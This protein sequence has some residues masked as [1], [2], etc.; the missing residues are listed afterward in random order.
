MPNC[1][2][3]E[4]SSQNQ[5]YFAKQTGSLS[6]EKVNALLITSQTMMYV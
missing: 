4:S 6:G 3:K 2:V 5:I 1:V